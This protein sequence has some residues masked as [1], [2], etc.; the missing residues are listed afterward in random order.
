MKPG[1][2]SKIREKR[3][4]KNYRTRRKPNRKVQETSENQ[5]KKIN[6][7]PLSISTL[8]GNH[9]T[10][11]SGTCQKLIDRQTLLHARFPQ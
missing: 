6:L 3:M 5:E 9:Q 10:Y 1:E 11:P 2:Q 8:M 4:K 7:L